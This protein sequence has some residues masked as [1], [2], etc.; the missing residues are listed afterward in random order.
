MR[1]NV[2]VRQRPPCVVRP[3][4]RLQNVTC[5]GPKVNSTYRAT[6]EMRK[7]LGSF[8]VLPLGKHGDA[9]HLAFVD[10]VEDAVRPFCAV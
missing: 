10:S 8:Y 6:A 5:S 4:A 1:E 3:F 9:S 7:V 2:E